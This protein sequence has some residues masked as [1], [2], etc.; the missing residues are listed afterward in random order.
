VP[1]SGRDAADPAASAVFCEY[2]PYEG[3]GMTDI[4]CVAGPRYKLAWNRDDR[5]ELYDT[6][7]D[8]LELANRIDDPALAAVRRRLQER[9]L[10]WMRG[11]ADPLA[12]VAAADLSPLLSGAGQR[13]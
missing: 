10:A 2:K 4:R 1:A 11:T 8:P 9:L 5:D 13:G 6:W 12:A 3:E 7:A